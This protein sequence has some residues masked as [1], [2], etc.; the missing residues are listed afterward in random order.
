MTLAYVDTGAFLALLR[1]DDRDHERMAAVFRGLRQE[2]AVLLT[3]EAV[4]AETAT[5]LRYDAGLRL[6]LAF[7]S[8]L[9]RPRHK[10]AS[11]WSRR[12]GRSAAPRST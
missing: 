1:S 4:V 8:A 6:A 3:C 10:G 2:R 9:D 12:T 7:R 5:R 11:A